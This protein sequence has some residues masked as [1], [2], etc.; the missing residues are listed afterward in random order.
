Q[1]VERGDTQSVFCDPQHDL[2]RRLIESHFGETLTPAAWQQ[3][4]TL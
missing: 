4:V 3:P 1:V 2:T